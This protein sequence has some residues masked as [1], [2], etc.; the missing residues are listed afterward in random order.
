MSKYESIT[1]ELTMITED[2]ISISMKRLNEIV[3]RIA[4]TGLPPSAF[5]NN[6]RIWWSNNKS[7]GAGRQCSGWLNAGWETDLMK[8][9]QGEY[10]T[11][12]RRPG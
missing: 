1:N 11:F 7:S 9:K 4:P 8:S 5:N 3:N 6:W 12:V 10:I 2:Q